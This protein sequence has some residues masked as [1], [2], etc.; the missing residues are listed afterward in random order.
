VKI[1]FR[2]RPTPASEATRRKRR[3]SLVL[4]SVGI[5][6]LPLAWRGASC[7]HDFDF[8]LESW[9]EVVRQWHQGVLYPHWVASANYGAGEPRFVFYPPLSWMLGALLGAILPWTWT[10]LALTLIALLAMSASFFQMAREWIPE[11]NAAFAACLYVLNP[12]ILFVAY[13]RTAYGELLAGIWMPLLVL[14]ALRKAPALPQLALV[15]AALWLTN[16]PGA[17][18]G[19][20]TLALIV[21]WTALIERRWVL[22]ARAAGAVALGLSLSSFY[23]VPAVYEQRWVEI[24]RAIAQGMRIEDSFLFEHTGEAFHDQVL[25]TAS[26]IAVT[27]LA[28]TAIAAILSIRNRQSAPRPESETRGTGRPGTR[29]SG[30]K[31]ACLIP[32]QSSFA[33]GRE[34]ASTAL[35]A[36]AVLIACLLLPFSDALWRHA[37]ELKFLQFPWRW[38]LVLSLIAAF[39]A[40]TALRSEARTRRAILL[41]ALA[42]LLLACAMSGLAWR[43]FWQ[44]CDDEDNIRAQLATFNDTGFEG[45]DEYTA[46]PA[47]NG[48]I[49]QHLP[50]VRILREASADQ[51]DSSIAENPEWRPNPSDAE[52]AQIHIQRWNVEHISATIDSASP[53]FAVLRLMDYPAWRVR[54][55][56][57]P[58]SARPRRDDGLMTIPIAAGTSRIEVQYTA[59]PDSW[60]GRAISL[61]SI[62]IL[63][64]Y[65][66]TQSASRPRQQLS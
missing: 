63:L 7:G 62:L 52:P 12:Y 56:G 37:P 8:H 30:A 16:A 36:A 64:V 42:I 13:E 38:L 27:L 20:Y 45:T 40:G 25:H 34:S 46:S 65:F 32:S 44:P 29:A 61:L 60:I 51:A 5:A 59:T 33:K 4:A 23:L 48:D 18:M 26:W 22:I 24:T 28:F 11:D 50:Q 14:Y 3:R 1:S 49:Q 41:R 39:L 9:M 31:T 15:I 43:S 53:A 19:C 10:P 6:L 17:V 54:I 21:L 66:R 47:D 58:A 2:F 55:N 57:H 35:I